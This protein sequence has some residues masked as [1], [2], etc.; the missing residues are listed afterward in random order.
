MLGGANDASFAG[1][2]A[3][4]LNVL[5]GKLI[6]HGCLDEPTMTLAG[7]LGIADDLIAYLDLGDGL[8][9]QVTHKDR[10]L[11]RQAPRAS[12]IAKRHA[13]KQGPAARLLALALDGEEEIVDVQNVGLGHGFIKT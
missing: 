7:H 3:Q 5:T 12:Q 4:S 13:N 11:G 2:D 1:A 9:A 8:I 10:R 6:G